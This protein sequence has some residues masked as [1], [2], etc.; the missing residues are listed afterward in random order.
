MAQQDKTDFYWNGALAGAINNLYY[1]LIN[2]DV[3]HVP[4][5]RTHRNSSF[6]LKTRLSYTIQEE[7]RSWTGKQ[8]DEWKDA[9]VADVKIIWNRSCNNNYWKVYV[10]AYTLTEK[11]VL[12]ANILDWCVWHFLN[13]SKA[14]ETITD[15]WD[16]WDFK[17]FTTN[18]VKWRKKDPEDL[19]EETWETSVP[20]TEYWIQMNKYNLW[21]TIWLFTTNSVENGSKKFKNIAQW[22]YI[23]VYASWNWDWDWFAGQVRMVTGFDAKWRLVLD[24]PWE[25]FRVIDN[26]TLQEWEEKIQQ[27]LHVQRAM[28]KEWWE[29][30]WYS[31]RKSVTLMNYVWGDTSLSTE[32]IDVY[33]GRWW[34]WDSWEIIWVADANDKIFILT[35]NGFIHYSNKY[36][37]DKFFINDDMYAWVDK[38]AIASY[39]NF[40]LAFW[41]DHIAVW[42]P[43]EKNVYYT[44]YNQ[45]ASIWTWSRYSFWEYEWD[46]IFVSNDK[47]LLAL[48]SS[49]TSGNYMLEFEDIGGALRLN[50]K[51]ATMLD[52]DEVFIWNDKNNLRVFVQTKTEPYA[53][54]WATYSCVIWFDDSVANNMTHI[55]KFDTLFKIWTE[56]HVSSLMRWTWWG[57]Y[58]WDKWLY[59]RAWN[60]KD[61]WA[62][63]NIQVRISAFMIE[64]E[65]NWLDW[66]PTLFQLAKLNRLITTLWPG[67]YTSST[68][69][70]MT[71]YSKWLGYTYE[72]PVNWDWNIWLWLMTS[73]YKWESLDDE[74]T[75]KMECLRTIVKDDQEEY[76]PSCTEKCLQPIS[77]VPE[78]PWC[79]SYKE[80]I[81]QEHNI[82][83]N[84]TVYELAPTMPLTTQFGNNQDYATQIKIEL[85]SGGGDVISFWWWLAELFIAPL[86]QKWPDWEYQLQPNTDC[87]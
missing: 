51:L 61:T 38:T 10:M 20:S 17:M 42:V 69:L 29:V 28:F 14:E 35:K 82:C 80:F 31:S 59:V 71:S 66:H 81:I 78:H 6:F 50:G 48:K 43:D 13:S 55:Y 77:L 36:W 60:K 16:C 25:W 9:K 2:V 65:N 64:N 46:M 7:R 72:F 22:D 37:Y 18:Y 67:I 73:Y 5:A 32:V 58:Y 53:S 44:M 56:D 87:D 79:D 27:G 49:T 15:I 47:R 23:L 24:A 26:T 30:V 83:V 85:I 41:R 39:K 68:K 45:L 1:D 57:I 52:T 75:E 3:V 11:R 40:L 86:F 74:D 4:Y 84:D 21:T 76:K 62:S 70:K 8:D 19:L 34:T 54:S 12:V 63:E 33:N